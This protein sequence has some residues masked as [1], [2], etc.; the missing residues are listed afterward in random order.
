MVYGNVGQDMAHC[1]GLCLC[2]ALQSSRLSVESVGSAR[3]KRERLSSFEVYSSRFMFFHAGGSVK[4]R[5]PDEF[6]MMFGQLS[7]HKPG[8]LSWLVVR[9]NTC[10]M[11]QTKYKK[12]LVL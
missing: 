4:S 6:S 11:Q 2:S 8:L 1:T 3:E 5:Q 10:T 7:A 12:V 9:F